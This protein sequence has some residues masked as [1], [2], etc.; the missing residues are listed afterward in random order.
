[1][2]HINQILK[3]EI[4]ISPNAINQLYGGDI[5]LVYHCIFDD[6]HLVIKVNDSKK[7]PQM[8]EKE[9]LGLDLLSR[10]YFK[11][12]EVISIG[13]FKEYDYIIIE[14]IKQG[15]K[16]TWDLFGENLAKLHRI[17][18]DKFGLD[19]NNYIGSL[20]Q[21][22]SFENEWSSFYCNNR[23]LNLTKIARNK[24]LIDKKDCALIDQLCIDIKN[25]IPEAKPSLI[26]GDLWSGNLLCNENNQPVLID[27]A[28][29]YGHPE[30]DWS[31]LALFGDYPESA[32]KKY[33]EVYPLENGFN[34]RKKIHQLY[35]LLVHLILF[36]RQYYNSV[37]RIILKFS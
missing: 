19:H 18:N 8:F 21:N 16:L 17:S 23:I 14:Y 1:L 34:E 20:V 3:K 5:N 12:P 10:S 4:G 2:I 29:Y 7:F 28:V 26:H 25:I 32:F 37:K 11:V 13:T 30:M 31:M 24:K 36:G 9:K 22:N 35:P 33:K 15:N 27:P 6:K